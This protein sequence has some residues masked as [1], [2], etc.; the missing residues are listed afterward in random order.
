MQIPHLRNPHKWLRA[1]VLALLLCVWSAFAQTTQEDSSA[2]RQIL[3]RLDHLEQQN[4][5]LTDE[6]HALRTELAAS[7]TEAAGAEAGAAPPAAIAER[8]EVQERRIE[9]QAQTKV[10]S[11]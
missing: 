10:E 7:R 11:S 2:L 9:E 6:I 4:R 8:V 1:I 3:E 5:Q